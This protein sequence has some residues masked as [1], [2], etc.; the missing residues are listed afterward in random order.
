MEDWG[1]R[2]RDVGAGGEDVEVRDGF[3]VE[4]VDWEDVAAVSVFWSEVFFL[5]DFEGASLIKPASLWWWSSRRRRM[6]SACR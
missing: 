1:R 3:G 4:D 2:R 5:S 6:R